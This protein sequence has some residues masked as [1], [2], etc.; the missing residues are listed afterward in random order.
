MVRIRR[1]EPGDGPAVRSLHRLALEVTGT[2]P[3]DV[4]DTDD[5]RDVEGAYLDS[6]GEFL[7]AECEDGIVG[8]GGLK[9]DDAT[10]EG[11]LFRM[12][13]H[14]DHQRSGIGTA[15]LDRLEAAAREHGVEL[16]HAETATRQTAA[17]QF[18]P[19]H[20]YE[21]TAR[22]TLGEYHLVAFAKDL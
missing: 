22:R 17:T 14:P 6:G 12:R 10:A 21:E 11:E 2:D 15:L 3:A 18:Y 16:L 20:G 13:V 7:V 1:Y 4:P 9:V 5:L 19:A 8:M